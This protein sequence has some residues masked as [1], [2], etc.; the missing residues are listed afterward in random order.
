MFMLRDVISKVFLIEFPDE[1][2]EC[3]EEFDEVPSEL[4]FLDVSHEVLL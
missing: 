3:L 1:I 2:G 4:D